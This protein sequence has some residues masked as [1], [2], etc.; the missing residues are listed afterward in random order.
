MIWETEDIYFGEDRISGDY[1]VDFSYLRGYSRWEEV[2]SNSIVPD[3]V[4]NN[5]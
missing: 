1:D 4:Q 5:E 2:E 3:S